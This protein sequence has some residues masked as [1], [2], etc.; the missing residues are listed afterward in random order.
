VILVDPQGYE[1]A[2]ETQHENAGSHYG[3]QVN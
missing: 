2:G 1:G 3:D